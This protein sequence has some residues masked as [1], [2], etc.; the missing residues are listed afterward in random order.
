MQRGPLFLAAAFFEVLRF[1]ALML[2][3]EAVGLGEGSAVAT[4]V[5]RY[6]AVAQ[7]I[8]IAL[9]FFL[10][11]DE[12]RYAVY[13]PLALLVKGVSLFALVPLILLVGSLRG[14][15]GLLLLSGLAFL[16]ALAV[17]AIDA[18]GL[19]VLALYR[20]RKSVEA[21]PVAPGQGPVPQGA[22]DIETVEGIP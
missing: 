3:V 7:L 10:W 21:G 20:R 2:F 19:L 4:A 6:C 15:E 17:G 8:F 18:L 14:V 22:A 13:R 11:F 12:V 9:F 5:L 16:A 1:L